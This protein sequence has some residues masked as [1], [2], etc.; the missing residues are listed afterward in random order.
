MGTQ[1]QPQQPK[2]WDTESED[3]EPHYG[4]T[5]HHRRPTKPST[6]PHLA[7]LRVLEL[8][9]GV[10]G[11]RAAGETEQRHAEWRRRLEG[12]G[13]GA[14]GGA[15]GG[16]GATQGKGQGAEGQGQAGLG[17]N[18]AEG[19]PMLAFARL[20]AS[21]WAEAFCGSSS[22]DVGT[23]EDRRGLVASAFHVMHALGM[24]AAL[25]R[26]EGRL[27]MQ[28]DR[29]VHAGGRRTMMARSLLMH[30]PILQG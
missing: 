22:V 1:A 14:G 26:C 21:Q 20:L 15:G 16:V 29:V 18:Q 2:E 7:W 25:D 6:S 8:L 3:R 23:A 5:C 13:A 30:D 17:A 28:A 9:L 10:E 11:A 4:Y 12:A 19:P 27:A 24:H